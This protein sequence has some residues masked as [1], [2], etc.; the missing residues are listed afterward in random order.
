M[1]LARADGSFVQWLR[2]LQRVQLLILDDWGLVPLDQSAARDR[3]DL[4]EEREQTGPVLIASQIPVA[5]WYASIAAP[6]LADAL[7]DRLVHHAYK[8]EMRGESQRRRQAPLP[9]QEPSVSAPQET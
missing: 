5:D 6:T 8:I 7:L 4:L 2:K 1:Q 9:E 3:F